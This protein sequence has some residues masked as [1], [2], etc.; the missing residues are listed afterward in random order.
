LQLVPNKAFLLPLF[1]TFVVFVAFSPCGSRIAIAAGELLQIWR[2]PGF[3]KEFFPFELIRTFAD[4]EDK[5]TALKWSHDSKYIL[6]GSKDLTA[7]LFS[8][9]KTG[10]VKTKPSRFGE[11]GPP[12]S[13]WRPF[14]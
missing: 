9:N 3:K 11:P 5:V 8:V 6:A 4:F 2:A 14:S 7:R 10:V 1:F 12:R 13:T